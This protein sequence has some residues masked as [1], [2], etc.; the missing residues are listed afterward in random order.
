MIMYLF[1][2]VI[3]LVKVTH[4]N[5]GHTSRSNQCQGQIRVTSKEGYPYVG[6]LHLN[7]TRSCLFILLNF[8]RI[9]C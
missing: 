6:S 2:L 5:Q 1:Q 3:P 7:Q 8:K 4:Q 9:V